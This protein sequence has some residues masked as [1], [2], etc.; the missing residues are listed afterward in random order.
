MRVRNWPSLWALKLIRKRTLTVS[1]YEALLSHTR[2]RWQKILI[3]APVTDEHL[4]LIRENK[5]P[6]TL[7]HAGREH[8][9]NTCKPIITRTSKAEDT[10][11]YLDNVTAT[12]VIARQCCATVTG[13]VTTM[14]SLQA[15]F[16]RYTKELRYSAV[17]HGIYSKDKEMVETNVSKNF[18]YHWWWK[19]ILEI[20]I[21][22]NKVCYMWLRPDAEVVVK[23]NIR[24]SHFLTLA[25]TS[26]TC[27]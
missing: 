22:S 25:P 9:Q 12:F 8:D 23:N 19:T 20:T 27:F 7:T 24:V 4:S 2:T 6:Q 5:P 26:L 21:N 11:D 16:T 17:L 1:E 13:H 3:C 18:R 10:C 14:F 15:S